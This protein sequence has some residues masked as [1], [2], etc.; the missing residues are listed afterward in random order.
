[1]PPTHDTAFGLLLNFFN[2]FIARFSMYFKEVSF[3]HFSMTILVLTKKMVLAT[4][5]I[6][7]DDCVI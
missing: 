2:F 1:M 4:N 5:R 7:G 6:V 3:F